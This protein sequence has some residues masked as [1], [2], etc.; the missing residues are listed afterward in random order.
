M[1]QTTWNAVIDDDGEELNVKDLRS[2]QLELVKRITKDAWDK[3][4][5]DPGKMT[6]DEIRFLVSSYYGVQDLR[7]LLKNRVSA[8]S[9]Q[10]DPATMFDFVVNGVEITE[11]NIQKFLAFASANKPIGQWAESIRGVGPVI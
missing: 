2:Y 3:I 8:L 7:K 1:A 4:G 6:K 11:K 9:K 10:D 5:E